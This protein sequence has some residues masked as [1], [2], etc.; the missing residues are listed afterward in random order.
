MELAGACGA[1]GSLVDVLFTANATVSTAAF[2]DHSDARAVATIDVRS[3]VDSELQ[4]VICASPG[5]GSCS[6]S[7]GDTLGIV[8]VVDWVHSFSLDL[9]VG[10]FNSGVASGYLDPI[11]FVDP[12]FPNAGLYSI[13]LSPG[14]ANILPSAGTSTPEPG[15]FWLL[16]PAIGLA[17]LPRLR[18]ASTSR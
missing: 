18:R 10:T 7:F 16:V 2:D 13:V 4:R 15:T 12:K 8:G 5:G 6:N 11:I 17:L 14:V 1:S 3:P 9:N